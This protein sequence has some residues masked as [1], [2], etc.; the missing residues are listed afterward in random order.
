MPKLKVNAII[1]N[2][3]L[4]KIGMKIDFENN[5]W[6]LPELKSIKYSINWKNKSE[7]ISTSM[8][9]DVSLQAVWLSTERE[10]NRRKGNTSGDC[11]QTEPNNMELDSGNGAYEFQF[12]RTSK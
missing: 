1:G 5:I 8:T 3:M 4:N 2:D 9:R 12:R 7:P 11:L 10:K 6:W